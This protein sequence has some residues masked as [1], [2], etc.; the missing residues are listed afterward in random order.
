MHIV[1]RVLIARSVVIST[2]QPGR[3]TAQYLWLIAGFEVEHPGALLQVG[4]IA[5][6]EGAFAHYIED[7][8]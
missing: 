5:K 3:E 2:L 4:P 8:R 1:I 6:L 7:A